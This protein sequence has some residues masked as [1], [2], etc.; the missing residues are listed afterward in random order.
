MKLFAKTTKG[1]QK[2]ENE[3]RI[4]VNKTILTDGILIADFMDGVIA[5]ADGVGGNN[6]GG[7][8]SHFVANQIGNLMQFDN[9]HFLQIN[10]DLF[11]KAEGDSALSGMATT[12]SGIV[13]DNDN[14]NAFHVGNTRI[15]ALAGG[16]YLNQVTEDDT[17]VNF[18]VKSGQISDD[19]IAGFSRKNEITACFGG[20]N[21]AL[22]KISYI[23]NLQ[24]CGYILSTDGIHDY[25]DEDSLED[26]INMY[27]ANPVELCNAIID[28]ARANGSMDDAS[29]I[30]VI[31]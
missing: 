6:A 21:R 3:D 1:P 2:I 27:I 14:L 9:D 4:I 25:I 31:E 28:K 23:S 19:E 17:T 15:Y 18:L 13:F 7:V 30:I 16:K 12:L 10:N 24:Q 11:K 20:N 22:L 29:I 8:A 26:L 5:I